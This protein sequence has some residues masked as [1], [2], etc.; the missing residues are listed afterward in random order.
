MSRKQRMPLSEFMNRFGTEEHCRDYLAAQRW[1]DGFVC[2]KCGHKHSCRLSNGLY[3]CTHCHRQTSVT[4][5]TVL[6]HSHVSLSKWFLAFYF[7]SQDKRGVSAVQL[8]NQIGVTY[9]TAWSM[10]RRIRS[11]MGQRDA[12][13][14]LSGVVEFDDAYFGGPATGGKRGRGTEKAKVFVALSLDGHGNPQY[15]KMSVAK[16][17]KQASVR[18]FASSAVAAGSTIRSDGYRSYIPALENYIHEHKPYDP[19]GGMLHW[20]HI[21]VSNAKA[22]ILG[23]Y[24]GLSKDHLQSYLDEFAFRF[25]RRAFGCLLTQRLILAVA[26]SK[27]AY[28]KG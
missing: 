9:K 15:L 18:K 3:Q 6:H 2:P 21:V 22:F 17:I 14:L 1:P 13:H 27:L 23:T 7:V 19:N 24:H 11:A 8:S 10:L 16:N 12:A 26:C 28:L 5:G 4:A 20:L 25:S